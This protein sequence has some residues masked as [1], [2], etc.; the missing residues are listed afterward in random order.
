M[1]VPELT[2]LLSALTGKKT[3]DA[4]TTYVSMR[5]KSNARRRALGRGR[6]PR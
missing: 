3:S 6:N 4:P 2:T 1:S 5:R